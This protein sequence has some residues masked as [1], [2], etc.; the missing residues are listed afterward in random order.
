MGQLI[1]RCGAEAPLLARSQPNIWSNIHVA[2]LVREFVPW[3]M[4]LS[5]LKT[6]HILPRWFRLPKAERLLRWGPEPQDEVLGTNGR[7]DDTPA[8]RPALRTAS[9]SFGFRGRGVCEA[10]VDVASAEVRGEGK[11]CF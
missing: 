5:R 11:R 3:R 8:A 6:S 4:G 7:H 10:T 9:A 2:S 1:P